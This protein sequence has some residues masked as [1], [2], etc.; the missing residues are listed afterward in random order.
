VNQHDE[1]E[2]IQQ[3]LNSSYIKNEKIQ[4]FTNNRESIVT[5][6]NSTNNV[7]KVVHVTNNYYINTSSSKFP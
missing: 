1:N 6:D 3:I 5:I 4:D 7:G 2:R